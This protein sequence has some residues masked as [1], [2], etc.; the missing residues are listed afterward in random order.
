MKL[1][2]TL[3]SLIVCIVFCFYFCH[4]QAFIQHQ[5]LSYRKIHSSNLYMKQG[6]DLPKPPKFG[7]FD[8]AKTLVSEL[9]P[10]GDSNGGFVP[11]YQ[12][13]REMV[14][15]YMQKTGCSREEAE[16]EVEDYMNDKEGWIKR[17]TAEEKAAAKK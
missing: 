9:S 11:I 2:A 7:F 10:F 15:K 13:K 12:K 16:R 14:E 8:F 1:E 17:K 6:D 3:S 5:S 4:V